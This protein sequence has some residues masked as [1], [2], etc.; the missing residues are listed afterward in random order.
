[1]DERTEGTLEHYFNLYRDQYGQHKLTASLANMWKKNINC[2]DPQVLSKAFENMLGNNEYAF[3][4]GKLQ[5]K[6][7]ETAKRMAGVNKPKEDLPPLNF[8][9]GKHIRLMLEMEFSFKNGGMTYED[10]VERITDYASF[11]L[12]GWDQKE[13]PSRLLEIKA[14]VAN[15]PKKVKRREGSFEAPSAQEA[16]KDI[17]EEGCVCLSLYVYVSLCVSLSV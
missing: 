17:I 15:N 2:N 8:E 9:A 10:F 12:P 14:W 16:V 13:L 7:T 4:W 1:M 3:P 6:I 11:H 5:D